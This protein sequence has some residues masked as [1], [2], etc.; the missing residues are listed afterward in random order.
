M[1]LKCSPSNHLLYRTILCFVTTTVC[2]AVLTQA[3]VNLQPVL[4]SPLP[5]PPSSAGGNP[6][7][8][9]T[10]ESRYS[11][12][13]PFIE[14][15]LSNMVSC[16][17]WSACLFYSL[18]PPSPPRTSIES[19]RQTLSRDG[20]EG[21]ATRRLGRGVVHLIFEVSWKGRKA[22]WRRK[23]YDKTVQFEKA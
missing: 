1:G 15:Q 7:G 21:T 14:L 12:Q 4:A 9:K 11:A 6:D 20:G 19:W 3:M 8:F 10:G 18:A 5:D 13:Y 2:C 17:R 16:N 22:G 23:Q